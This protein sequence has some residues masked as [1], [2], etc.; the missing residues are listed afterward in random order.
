[1]FTAK[2]G[3]RMLKP[4]PMTE[5][6]RERL[7][8]VRD[9][10]IVNADKRPDLGQAAIRA[11]LSAFHFHRRFKFY[12]G[13]TPKRIVFEHQIEKAKQLMLNGEKL[14]SVATLCGFA[15]QAHFTM[16]FRQAVG[17]TPAEWL[18]RQRP[19]FGS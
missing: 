13:T 6:E 11:R 4:G 7:E 5:E 17:Q 18:S 8:A 9:W 3:G 2:P 15:H 19:N 10:L 16:R 14:K 1:M 12:F